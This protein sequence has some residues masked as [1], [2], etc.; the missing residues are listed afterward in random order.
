M[1]A[2]PV[3]QSAGMHAGPR[4]A[5]V[6]AQCALAS[7]ICLHAHTHMAGQTHACLDPCRS[8][9]REERAIGERVPRYIKFLQVGGHEQ[10][11]DEYPLD[12]HV[13]ACGWP[14]ARMHAVTIAW[15][16]FGDC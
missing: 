5:L 6:H 2:W 8:A 9:A 11:H 3:Q 10:T 13:T 4:V 7:V 1:S 16:L 14:N 12:F 15:R